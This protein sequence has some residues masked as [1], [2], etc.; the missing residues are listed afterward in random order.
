MKSSGRYFGRF[1]REFVLPYRTVVAILTILVLV[2]AG[3]GL[4]WPFSMKILVDQ[5]LINPRPSLDLALVLLGS[6]F[7][8]IGL[9]FLLL[10][11]FN[12]ALY[13]LLVVVTQRIRTRVAD[14][15]LALPQAFYDASHAGRLLTTAVSDPDTI[16]QTLTAGVINASANAFTVLGGYVILARMS[17]PLTAAITIVF[18]ITVII[19]FLLRPRIIEAGQRGR[20]NWG[21]LS[22]MVSEKIGAVRVVRSFAQEELEAD[23]FR[24]RVMLHRDIHMESNHLG[25]LYGFWNGLTIHFGYIIVFVLGGWLYI[26]GRTTLGTIVAFYGYFQALWP[27]VLQICNLQQQIASASGSLSKVFRLLDEPLTIH[28]NPGAVPLREP[29]RGIVFEKV[30]FRYGANLPWVLRQVSFRLAAGEALGLVGP[31]GA[32]KSTLM[33]LLLRFYEPT[34]GRILV[35]GKPLADWNLGDLRRVFGLVPQDVILF[36]GPLRDNVRYAQGDVPEE[37]IWEALEEA[38][39][40]GFVR[41]IPERLL[42]RVGEHGLS[43]SGGQ[44]QRISIARALLTK[45][46]LLV[47]DN[48]TSALDS[49]TEAR[50]QET[51]WKIL[52][53]RPNPAGKGRRTA[54]IISHRISS[55]MR[56]HRII[57]LDGGRIIEQGTAEELLRRRGYFHGIHEEQTGTR[58]AETPG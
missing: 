4:W 23:R 28:N 57:V 38:E 51:L 46:E 42:A 16:T 20:E 13:Q 56:C 41:E 39:A 24:Q 2:R 3:L 31:S 55:V 9:N 49:E 22:G 17:L 36:S 45:P 35:N 52:E 12:R 8:V 58:Q 15:L 48:C 30:S 32:G 25:A 29:L 37:R 43:L 6:G 5:V 1:L 19:Y 40:A 18:P 21:I 50:L 53:S 26:Q 44:K 54:I 47:L 34:E 11:F 33:A 7:A 10:Y 14:H 27:A